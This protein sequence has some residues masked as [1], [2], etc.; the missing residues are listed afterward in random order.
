V[1][2][3][4]VNVGR[5]L[6]RVLARLVMVRVGVLA[7]EG[8]GERRIVRVRM[9]AIVVTVRMCVVDCLVPMPVPVALGDVQVDSARE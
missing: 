8:L 7:H 2:V 5:V 1:G 4:V 3:P 9:V 6:V